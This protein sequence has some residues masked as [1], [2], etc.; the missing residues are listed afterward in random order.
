MPRKIRPIVKVGDEIYDRLAAG[1]ISPEEAEELLLRMAFG[2]DPERLPLPWKK[3][4]R[5]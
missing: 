2:E 4:R 3:K 1:K 5:K